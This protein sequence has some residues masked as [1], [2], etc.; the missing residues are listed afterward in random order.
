MIR[1]GSNHPKTAGN[2]QVTCNINLLH[3]FFVQ[4]YYREYFWSYSLD[5]DWMPGKGVQDCLF[6][7]WKPILIALQDYEGKQGTVKRTEVRKS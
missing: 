2:F 3:V 4:R 6:P 1:S 7:R 5:I